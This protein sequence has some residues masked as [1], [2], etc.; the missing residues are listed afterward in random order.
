MINYE[1]TRWSFYFR[2]IA[3]CHPLPIGSQKQLKEVLAKRFKKISKR[4]PEFQMLSYKDREEVMI[5]INS[6]D[7]LIFLDFD[8]KYPFTCG[9]ADLLIFQAWRD[10]AGSVHPIDGPGGGGHAVQEA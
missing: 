7:L 10:L 4:I 5:I 6:M 1:R 2:M 3:F 8:S 9:D